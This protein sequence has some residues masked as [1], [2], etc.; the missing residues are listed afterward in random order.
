MA[1]PTVAR[2]QP[3]LRSH[4]PAA[5][6]SLLGPQGGP[7]VLSSMS[8]RLD[9]QTPAAHTHLHVPSVCVYFV[10]LRFKHLS[11]THRPSDTVT[12]PGVI[13]SVCAARPWVFLGDAI[14]VLNAYTGGSAC[15]CVFVC[16]CARVC[17]RLVCFYAQQ[18]FIQ[19]ITSVHVCGQVDIKCALIR[20]CIF[21]VT[22]RKLAH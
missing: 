5:L 16:V 17:Q 6:P 12:Q 1:R 15:V 22:T 3:D 21:S 8:N 13:D 20:Q 14:T 10:S 9:P 4:R 2:S 7:N 11:R 18:A 19:H